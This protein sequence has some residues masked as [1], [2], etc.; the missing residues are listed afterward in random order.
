VE[1]DNTGQNFCAVSYSGG[2]DSTYMLL[3][4]IELGMPIDAVLYA[5]TGME[6]PEMYDHLQKVDEFLFRERG[7]H[8]TTLRHPK[9]FEYMMFEEPKTKTSCVENRKRLGIPLIGNGWPGVKVRWCTGQLKAHLLEKEVNRLKQEKQ[10]VHFV[11][12]AADEAWRCKD[13]HYPL[14]EW[15]TTEAEALRGCY[16]RGFTFG[17]LYDI[18]RRCSC[19][20]CPFQRI[21]ELRNL[22]CFH[23]ELWKK[24][25][26]MD[27]RAIAQFGNTPLGTFKPNWTVEKLDQRFADE[28]KK[29]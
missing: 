2:K 10:A 17:G 9:G 4:M 23:P 19:W 15:G 22:R 18:Y 25:M 14:V 16:E 13:A 6:F 8:M 12:I 3:R 5:D 11:G 28:E 27:R 20:C 21:E 29:R 7:F 26:E 1:S 24:L